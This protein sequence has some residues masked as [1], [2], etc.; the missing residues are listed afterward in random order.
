MRLAKGKRVQREFKESF[1]M[2]WPGE[3]R[4]EREFKESLGVE[5]KE[6]SKRVYRESSTK[7][8]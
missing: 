6:S 1:G 8:S 5:C 7:A 3:E 2:G 4:V